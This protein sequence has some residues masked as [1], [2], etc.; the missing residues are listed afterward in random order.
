MRLSL[1]R[2]CFTMAILAP[3][4]LSA[5]EIFE[6]E[7]PTFA[8]TTKNSLYAFDCYNCIDNGYYFCP[9]DAMCW[10]NDTH[11]FQPEFTLYP[12]GCQTPADLLGEDPNLCSPPENFFSDP[13][14]TT[15]E[16]VFDMINVRPVWEKGYFGASVRWVSQLP[17]RSHSFDLHPLLI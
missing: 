2:N 5:D 16:W 10:L 9:F 4:F 12:Y 13:L 8:P 17:S 11:P 6:T 3:S 1:T 7:D 14:Y 15:N